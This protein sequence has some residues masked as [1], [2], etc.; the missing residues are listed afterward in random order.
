MGGILFTILQLL[1]LPNIAIAGISYFF[2][3]GF[4]LGT[5]TLIS[6]LTIDLNSLPAIPILGSLPTS[7]HPLLLIS[8]VAPILIISLNQLKVFR[9][10][11]E[12]KDR[13]SKILIGII[14]LIALLALFSFLA[15][16][17]LLTQ[18]MHPV[19]VTWWKLPA[20]VAVIQLL[21]LI[22]GLY[23]PKLIRAIKSPKAEI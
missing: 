1:Y 12:F 21:T 16:G 22:L 18:D 10:H 11:T 8:L 7:E 4:S 9:K 5:D 17:T 23:L 3:M 2:G 20:L 6:P 13:Q 15:G 19:G 14:P